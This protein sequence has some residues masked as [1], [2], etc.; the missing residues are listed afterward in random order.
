MLVIR[1]KNAVILAL[2]YASI[3]FSGNGEN[4]SEGSGTGPT[5]QNSGGYID[6]AEYFNTAADWLL[7][8]IAIKFNVWK[9]DD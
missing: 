4:V 3:G 2:L 5:F 1:K 6:E 7:D 9:L 8:F